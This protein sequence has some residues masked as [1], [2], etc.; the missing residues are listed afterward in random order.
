MQSHLNELLLLCP[1]KKIQGYEKLI[2][3]YGTIL[4]VLDHCNS[5]AIPEM[6]LL[7]TVLYVFTSSLKEVFWGFLII[8]LEI[9]K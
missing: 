8:V 9:Y 1:K 2:H 3:F 6:V 4:L 7:A 5:D